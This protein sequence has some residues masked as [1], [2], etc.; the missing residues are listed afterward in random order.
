MAFFRPG[1]FARFFSEG[2]VYGR[3]NVPERD[4]GLHV[5][6]PS[7]I[8]FSGDRDLHPLFLEV[9]GAALR[10]HY[11]I[12]IGGLLHCAPYARILMGFMNWLEVM[13]NR[14][15]SLEALNAEL[16]Q[17]FSQV[18]LWLVGCNAFFT[19]KNHKDATR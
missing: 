9:R 6:L 14:G 2:A 15:D 18:E 11:S 3:W 7:P 1:V 17:R 19:A 12:C 8:R 10:R 4:Q 13:D 16:S 5:F